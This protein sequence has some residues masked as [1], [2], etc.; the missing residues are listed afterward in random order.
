MHGR[1]SPQTILIGEAGAVLLKPLFSE[2]IEPAYRAPERVL[3]N[4]PDERSDIFSFGALLFYE[5]VSGDVPF[6][7]VGS[8]PRSSKEIRP[9]WNP[10]IHLAASTLPKPA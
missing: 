5:L 4:S 2:R 10:M 9:R 1:I 6:Q 3:G 7:G 8:E